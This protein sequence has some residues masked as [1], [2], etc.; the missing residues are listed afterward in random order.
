MWAKDNPMPQISADRPGQ[1]F[2]LC[3]IAHARPRGRMR[4]NGGGR[5]GRWDHPTCQG[6]DRPEHPSPKPLDLMLEQVADFT[7]PGE[8]VLDVF[9]GSGTTGVACLRL[10]RRVI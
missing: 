4:W 5:G 6:P 8:L 1:A 3:T 2:E 9:A 7:D 10:D